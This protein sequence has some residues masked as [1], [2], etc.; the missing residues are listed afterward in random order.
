[1]GRGGYSFGCVV[2]R[3]WDP[4]GVVWLRSAEP[5]TRETKNRDGFFPQ[6]NTTKEHFFVCLNVL[7]YLLLVL[8]LVNFGTKS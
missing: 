5:H 1:M 3:A 6:R 2:D 4:F 7:A 8:L